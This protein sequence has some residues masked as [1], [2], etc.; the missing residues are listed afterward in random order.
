MKDISEPLN[1]FLK[2]NLN[3]VMKVLVSILIEKCEKAKF[4]Q[5]ESNSKQNGGQKDILSVLLVNIVSFF[6]IFV[7]SEELSCSL[8]SILLMRVVDLD[9]NIKNM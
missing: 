9:R 2:E 6:S 3:I 7:Y 1:E 5:E 4:Y 8:E